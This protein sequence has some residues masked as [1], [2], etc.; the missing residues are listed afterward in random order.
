MTAAPT[1]RTTEVAPL[2]NL[3][4][5]VVEYLDAAMDEVRRQARAGYEQSSLL[6]E[7]KADAREATVASNEE[8]ANPERIEAL[9]RANAR[10]AAAASLAVP[11]YPSAVSVDAVVAVANL[12]VSLGRSRQVEGDLDA[13]LDAF[14]L[15]LD[16]V[17][18]YRAYT[19]VASVDQITFGVASRAAAAAGE[20]AAERKLTLDLTLDALDRN[21]ITPYSTFM[22][23][24]DLS[25]PRAFGVVALLRRALL[26]AEPEYLEQLRTALEGAYD[27]LLP[28]TP[29]ARIR[30]ETDMDA[31]LTEV[32][33]NLGR[34]QRGSFEW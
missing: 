33:I 21:I 27:S 23:S 32:D 13:A 8:Y 4:P 31:L 11:E 22:R 12:T 14:M 16:L 20:L 15:A 5:Y 25:G 9:S 17:R 26:R 19:R 28:S 18:V 10:V 29:S 2:S 6:S 24:D 34:K 30:F 7:A 1:S 3:A